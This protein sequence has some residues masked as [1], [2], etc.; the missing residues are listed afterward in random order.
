[1]NKGAFS[2]AAVLNA[3][4]LKRHLNE[5]GRPPRTPGTPT[6]GP[7]QPQRGRVH[8]REGDSPKGRF[9]KQETEVK[10]CMAGG[11]WRQRK[12]RGPWAN[13][14]EQGLR[15]MLRCTGPGRVRHRHLTRACLLTPGRKYSHPG[16]EREESSMGRMEIGWV[17]TQRV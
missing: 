16:G 7:P 8:S 12:D 4:R 13:V 15:L 1:M 6:L 10:P 2:A 14:Q 9:R 5:P 11:M 3:S 17:S